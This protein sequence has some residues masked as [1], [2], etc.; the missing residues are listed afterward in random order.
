MKKFLVGRGVYAVQLHMDIETGLSF[1]NVVNADY[2]IGTWRKIL[3]RV[4]YAMLAIFF[5]QDGLRSV[6][7]FGQS[8]L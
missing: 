1:L 2:E 7:C 6:L 4:V 3:M 5:V 8:N